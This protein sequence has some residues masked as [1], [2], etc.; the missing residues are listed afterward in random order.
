MVSLDGRHGTYNNVIFHPTKATVEAIRDAAHAELPYKIEIVDDSGA[1]V[2]NFPMY[3]SDVRY[4]YDTLLFV[5]N[6]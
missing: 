5:T 6:A 4:Q 3:I 2:N 1:H